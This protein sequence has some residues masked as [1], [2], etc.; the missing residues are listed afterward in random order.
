[1]KQAIKSLA[2][3]AGAMLLATGAQAA[4]LTIGTVTGTG[5]VVVS[6]SEPNT[7]LSWNFNTGFGFSTTARA[8]LG[9]A[10]LAQIFGDQG[11]FK[12]QAASAGVNAVDGNGIGGLSQ[13]Q[14]SQQWQILNT[15]PGNQ[16]SMFFGNAF[17]F[18]FSPTSASTGSID[19]DLTSDGFVHWYYGYDSDTCFDPPGPATCT[20]GRTALP[21]SAFDF[22]GGYTITGSSVDTQGLRTLSVSLTGTITQTVPEPA[23]L[24]LA[25]VALLAG[26]SATRRC[27][28][29]S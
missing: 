4:L 27:K 11:Q 24:A 2:V 6:D 7:P 12:F 20:N 16:N 1:M 19:G 23:S 28:Q 13:S 26:V 5:T 29:L 17:A 22:T 10:S 9:G 3:L 15:V 18:T 14:G 8:D 21:N 25:G